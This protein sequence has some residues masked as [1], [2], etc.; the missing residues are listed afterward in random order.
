MLI[1]SLPLAPLCSCGATSASNPVYPW[2]EE[3]LLPN[4]FC[5]MF[6]YHKSR[7]PSEPCSLWSSNQCCVSP[8]VDLPTSSR[9]TA[10]YDTPDE[11]VLLQLPHGPSHGES[12]VDYDHIERY[13]Q[14]YFTT[15]LLARHIMHVD[16][17]P[18]KFTS[19]SQPLYLDGNPFPRSRSSLNATCMLSSPSQA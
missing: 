19:T 7:H 4:S 6:A 16:V 10:I 2:L 13:A 11:I 18:P 5:Q 3:N 1:G 14:L 9:L 8:W 15:S 12:R 17:I